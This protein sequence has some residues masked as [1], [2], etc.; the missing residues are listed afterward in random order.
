VS[1]RFAQSVFAQSEREQAMRLP[2]QRGHEYLAGRFA[3]KEAVLKALHR[4]IENPSMMKEIEAVS[5]T[6]GR[7]CAVISRCF[8]VGDSPTRELVRSTR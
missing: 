4:G 2:E 7:P 6:D 8:S 1:A 3:V 5:Q